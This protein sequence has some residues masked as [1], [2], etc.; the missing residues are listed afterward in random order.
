MGRRGILL[1][2]AHHH[3]ARFNR[4]KRNDKRNEM[5]PIPPTILPK[6]RRNE[7]RK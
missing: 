7:A 4:H 3:S 2:A 5:P 6:K 1:H